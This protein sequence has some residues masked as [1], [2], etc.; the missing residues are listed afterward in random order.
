MVQTGTTWRSQLQFLAGLLESGQKDVENRE[1]LASS[2]KEAKQFNT[3][4]EMFLNGSKERIQWIQRS[5][6]DDTTATLYD[7]ALSVESQ[8]NHIFTGA[9]SVTLTSATLTIAG[10][11]DYIKEQLGLPSAHELKLD[12]SFAYQ[13]QMLIYIVD[14][15]VDPT[16]PSFDSFTAEKIERIS[17]LLSDRVLGLFTSHQS[18]RSVYAKA[19]G[20]LNKANIKLLAQ[21]ITGGRHNITNRFKNVPSSV[22]FGTYSFWEGIDA[23][24]DTLSCV[25]IPKLPF[26]IPNDPIY[27]ALSEALSVNTFTHFSLPQMILKLRQGVG[28]LLRSP[29]DTGAIVILDGRF[30]NREYGDQV[31]QSLPPGVVHIGSQADLI[32]TLE[33]W[34]TKE[35]IDKWH[36]DLEGEE[37]K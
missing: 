37:H 23:P 18:V 36:K 12:S 34:Y 1:L 24:G 14:N 28:R 4:L 16:A 20:A 31:L 8:L 19:L 35:V 33:K 25:V 6:P 26:P 7:Q 30:L 10:K 17:L 9:S 29:G 21:K 5:M 22:L 15:G 11:Y 13:D 3:E 2:V 32:P 27:E